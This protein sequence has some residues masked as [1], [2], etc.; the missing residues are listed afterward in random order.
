[1]AKLN[2]KL[3]NMDKNRRKIYQNEQKSAKI[4]ENRQTNQETKKNIKQIH[5]L[6]IFWRPDFDSWEFR[7]IFFEKIIFLW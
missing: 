5:D 4:H 2:K 3:I 7:S 1:M 6:I